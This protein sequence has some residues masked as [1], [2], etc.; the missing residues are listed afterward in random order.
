MNPAPSVVLFTTASGAGFGLLALLALGWPAPT[1]ALAF[2]HWF[3]AYALATG[4]LLASVAH[5]ARPSRARFALS[6]WRSSWLSREGVLAIAA[7]VIAA[8]TAIAAIVLSRQWLAPG[9]LAAALSFSTVFA[10]AMIYTQ[11]RAVPRWNMPL[12]PALFLVQSLAGGT[13]LAGYPRA[14]AALLIALTL[15]QIATWVRGDRR[16][17]EVAATLGTATGVAPPAR[18]RLFERS[19]TASDWVMDEMAFRIARKHAARLRLI[20]LALL[21]PVP[22]VV[23]LAASIPA[24]ALAAT[25]HLTGALICRWLF[26]AEAEHV[27][28]L[29]YGRH[30]NA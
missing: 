11:L 26:F 18:L 9:I 30:A 4:G 7:L 24:L 12:T 10:T 20:G 13:L 19:H 21:G 28:G 17:A 8:P 29:Y 2:G 15:I 3:L 27:V 16:F 6:Q 1:G 5:L 14:A 23:A 25:L 22:A